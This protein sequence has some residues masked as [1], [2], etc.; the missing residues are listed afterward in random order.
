MK[1]FAKLAVVIAMLCPSVNSVA[2]DD[3]SNTFN[4]SRVLR[5]AVQLSLF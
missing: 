5:W 4:T 2:E 3:T 1:N